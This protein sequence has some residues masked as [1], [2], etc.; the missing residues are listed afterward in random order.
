MVLSVKVHCSRIQT[1]RVKAMVSDQK[2]MWR[3]NNSKK[4]KNQQQQQ[5]EQKKQLE[6]QQEQHKD[7][8]RE[9][10]L[11]SLTLKVVTRTKCESK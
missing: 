11:L 6:Q 9:R 3:K 10:M 2:R 8:Q 4:Q 7:V 1:L 5:P